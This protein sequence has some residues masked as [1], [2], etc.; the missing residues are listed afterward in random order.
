MR[1]FATLPVYLRLRTQSRHKPDGVSGSNT[2]WQK[3]QSAER[4]QLCRSVCDSWHLPSLQRRHLPAVSWRAETI[5][6][7]LQTA[8][9]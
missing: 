5:S 6:G 3:W 2:I 8:T 4:Q 9:R 1:E 7:Q